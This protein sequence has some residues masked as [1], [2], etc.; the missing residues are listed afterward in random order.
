M[1]I[2]NGVVTHLNV[3]AP[4]EFKISDAETMLQLL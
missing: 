4:R 1:I 2:E 3:E